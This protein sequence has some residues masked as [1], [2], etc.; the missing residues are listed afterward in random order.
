MSDVFWFWF[1]LA[2]A[3]VSVT[4]VIV[5]VSGDEAR[6]LARAQRESGEKV[7]LDLTTHDDRQAASMGQPAR[8]SDGENW[9]L[10]GWLLFGAGV[11]ALVLSL[12]LKTT[13]GIV[14]PAA[15]G[16]EAT[17]EIVNI[18]LLFRK[19]LALGGSV[20]A[21]IMGLIAAAAGA[22]MGSFAKRD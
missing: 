7:D 5:T 10:F 21:M 2:L 17:S 19:G 20:A 1:V 6:A 15:L 3:G 14:V 18:D 22:I 13:L 4:A 12:N 8:K 16:G 9:R 11:V